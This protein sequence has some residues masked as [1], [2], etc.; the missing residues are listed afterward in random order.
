MHI[1]FSYICLYVFYIDVY[2][3]VICV[4]MFTL[5][6]CESNRIE[7][8]SLG[9]LDF[10]QCLAYCRHPT[11]NV[12]LHTCFLMKCCTSLRILYKY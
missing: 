4:C 2:M 3:Y 7:A 1:C 5:L 8:A 10:T 6:G 9:S 11:N 12:F